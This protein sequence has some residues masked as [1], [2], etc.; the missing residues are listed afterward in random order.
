MPIFNPF[1]MKKFILKVCL[2]L[3]V[4]FIIDR[5]VGIIGNYVACNVHTGVYGRDN[6][7]GNEATEDILVF[8]SSRAVHHYNAPMLSDSLG[9]TCYNCGD[10][11]CGIVLSYGRLLLNKERHS[12]KII[13]QDVFPPNDV[14]MGDN[15]RYIG[16]LK[17]F[18]HREG[19]A[20]MFESID[21]TQK[22]KMISNLYK[23]NGKLHHM[24]FVYL[25]P[26]PSEEGLQGFRPSNSA[27][28]TMKVVKNYQEPVYEVDSQKLEYVNKF[29]DCAGNAK[30]YFVVS[31]IWYG[32]NPQNLK[33][34]KDICK[35]RNV[36]FLDF[37]NDAKYVH[38]NQYFHDGAH[39][40]ADGADEFTKDLI[41]KIREDSKK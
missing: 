24:F 19:I 29:I 11:G 1:V 15:S 38:N 9:M 2:F 20:E 37:S 18:Y 13:I 3:A 7:I 33:P 17:S 23:Y 14:A 5:I 40:N 30:V 27:M 35:K 36:S 8:G 25:F 4:L 31:P 10:D 34:I 6:Y 21:K 32:M 41:K 28:D 12:P 16:F 22:Y 39:L 26:R